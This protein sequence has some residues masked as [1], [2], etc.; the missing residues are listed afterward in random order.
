VTLTYGYDTAGR[1]QTTT[2][3]Q[4]T[5][6]IGYSPTTGQ[7]ASRTAASGETTQYIYDGFLKTGTTWGGPVAGS[8]SLGFDNNFRVTSQTVNGTALGFGY[9][10]DGL[11]TGAGALTLTLDTQNGRLNRTTLGSMTDSYAYD[12]SRASRTRS[13]PSGSTPVRS[14]RVSRAYRA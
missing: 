9:D 11:L 6:S 1:L 3:P 4:G 13:L 8:L 12:A 10:L 2:Y 14:R 7:V 5:L